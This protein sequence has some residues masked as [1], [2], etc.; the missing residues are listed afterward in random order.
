[1]KLPMPLLVVMEAAINQYLAL[2]PD[3]LGRLSRLS[4]KVVGVELR[5][6]DLN[7]AVA[8]RADG[9]Q[10]LQSHEA[11]DCVLSGL[12]LS[13]LRTAAGD[14]RAFFEKAVEIRGDMD[15]GQRIKHLL[16]GIEVDWEEHLS[17]LTGDVLAHQVGN[18]VRGV[19]RWATQ[20]ADSLGRNV[21]EY[22][23][24]EHRDLPSRI[25]VEDFLD[26]VDR[27]RA[28]A[29]RLETRIAHLFRKVTESDA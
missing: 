9:V 4:G 2:D 20:S 28:D 11:P 25:E 17:R 24:E 26:D 13:M 19:Q 15:L 6:M 16:A 22:L 3:T 23:Q 21:S 1:M 12:P 7:F 18:V 27:L 10:L 5:G 29:A 14:N 8:L